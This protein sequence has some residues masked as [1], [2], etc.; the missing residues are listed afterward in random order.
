MQS[1]TASI[2]ML[3]GNN[4]KKT[5]SRHNYTGS[6]VTE[7]L[8]NGFFTVD[9]KWTVQYWNK[10]AEK[11]L[12]VASADIIGKNVREKFADL[13]PLEFYTVYQSAFLQSIPVHFE[14][15]WGQMGSWF[16]VITY[17]CDDTLSVSFKSSNK[18]HAEY[19]ENPYQRLKVLTELYKFVTE[20]TNDCLWEWDLH[21]KE[22]FWID[23]GHKKIFGYPIENAL[24][25][26]LFWESCLHP[27]DRQRVL[28]KLNTIIAEGKMDTWQDEYR[29]RKAN[30][31]YAYVCDRGHLIYQDGVIAR[32]IGATQDNTARVLLE[33]ELAAE[34]TARLMDMTNAVF[35]AQ[36]NERTAIGRE[37]HDNI[38][39]VL[40]IAKMNI[41]MAK[42][43]ASKSEFYLDK[44]LELV[45][46]VI[47][48]IRQLTKKMIIP[49]I[50]FTGLFENIKNLIADLSEVH[51]S[52]IAFYTSNL[53]EVEIG[54]KLQVNIYRIV[55]EQ[56]NNIL[57]HTKATY[58]DIALYKND[59]NIVL[60][61]SDNG[62]GC[63][64]GSVKK[65]VGSINIMSRAQLFHGT[66]HTI[67][68][69]GEG[70]LLK[71]SFPIAYN[72]T[73]QDQLPAV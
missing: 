47:S 55:Q 64:V 39:Q 36:E 45:S 33:N 12:G 31:E 1:G 63:E 61:I 65:G 44:S 32:I 56:L 50:E 72:L 46:S 28:D 71:I 29:F 70:Y 11:L 62:E 14:E 19:P 52:K 30:G 24:I 38:N 42:N 53:T 66:V 25:P 41:Q 20:I 27:D 26:Q 8:T 48:D 7:T 37:L 57:T 51:P 59:G 16:D 4:I 43:H 22:I 9:R 13:L 5:L 69:P 49:G 67:S 54:E 40:A 6:P 35:T 73:S 17:H 58:A 60:L 10:A 68:T 2:Q 18:P 15:Y 3:S 23:G 21:Q 34:R